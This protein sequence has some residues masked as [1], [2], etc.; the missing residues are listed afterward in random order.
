MIVCETERLRIRH[1]NFKDVEF[2]IK[3]L[4]EPAFV[5]NIADKGV[6]NQEDAI[7]Y[8]QDG[9]MASYK[10]FGFGL[11]MVELKDGTPLG[12]C[13]LIKREVLDDVDIGYAFLKEHGGQ[14]YA[15]ESAMA[16]LKDASSVHGLKRIVAIT[17]PSNKGSI[18]LLEK[19]GFKYEKMIELYGNDDMLFGFDIN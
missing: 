1:F 18:H 13:G 4:N 14:G 9:S 17:K 7:K 11:S 3:L 12:M 10:E 5:E 2:V 15:F 19:L 8:L 16:V 6:R